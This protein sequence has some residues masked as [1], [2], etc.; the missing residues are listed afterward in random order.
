M[1]AS[2]IVTYAVMSIVRSSKFI[3]GPCQ[4]L[5]LLRNKSKANVPTILHV[6]FSPK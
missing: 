2:V 3:V 1:V 5:T 6:G 4:N